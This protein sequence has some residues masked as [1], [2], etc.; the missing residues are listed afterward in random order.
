MP[1]RPN[2]ATSD[3]AIARVPPPDP[4][5]REFLDRTASSTG[6]NWSSSIRRVLIDEGRPVS[7]GFP[8][9][10]SEVR[11][12]VATLVGLALRNARMPHL[13]PEEREWS[14]R[15]AYAV[16]RKDWLANGVRDPEEGED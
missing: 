15:L 16:A 8:G 5:R 14:A 6:V 9:T 2:K 13:S 10:M 7:G 11:T 4:A 12:Q 1:S 3:E